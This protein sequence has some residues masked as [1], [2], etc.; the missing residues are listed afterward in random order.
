M[1]DIE[2]KARQKLRNLETGEVVQIRSVGFMIEYYN[3]DVDGSVQASRWQEFFELEQS[4]KNPGDKRKLEA[5][6]N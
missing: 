5:S 4:A 6:I 2:L 1:A 3:D